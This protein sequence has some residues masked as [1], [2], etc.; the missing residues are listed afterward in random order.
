MSNLPCPRARGAA[1]FTYVF[2]VVYSACAQ[3]MDV[4]KPSVGG[5][6]H[7]GPRCSLSME[8]LD[9]GNTGVGRENDQT[10][11]VTNTGT[12]PLVIFAVKSSCSCTEGEVASNCL[13]PGERTDLRVALKLDGYPKEAVDTFILIETNDPVTPATRLAVEAVIQPE[14]VV[15][16]ET[17]DFGTIKCGTRCTKTVS[18]V[19]TGPADLAITR[20]VTPPRVDASVREKPNPQGKAFEIAVTLSPA[21]E[22]KELHSHIILLTNIP[23]LPR[24]QIGI[25]AQFTG[26]ECKI[27]PNVLVIAPKPQGSVVGTVVVEGESYLRVTDAMSSIEGL[28]ATIE[29]LEPEKRYQI[30]LR[31]GDDLAKSDK[32]GKL[33]FNVEDRGLKELR[34]VPLYRIGSLRMPVIRSK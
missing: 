9:F 14:Y 26:V 22:Q 7:Q 5:D 10:V 30:V 8:T 19:Q 25:Q 2:L 23:R 24:H 16:P 3:Q 32:A 1:V 31:A 13:L 6:V 18:V 15:Q 28:S 11:I 33:A 21:P 27:V 17:L 12:E 20:V 29:E 4:P 34:E